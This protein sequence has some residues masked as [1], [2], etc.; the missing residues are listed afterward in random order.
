MVPVTITAQVADACSETTWK[1]ISISSNQ[2]VDAKGSGN[3]SPDWLITGDK[4]A[5][6]RAERTGKDKGGRIYTITIQA[7]DEAGNQ[8]AAATVTVTV[9]HDQGKKKK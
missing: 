4:T 9:P 7:T 2:A 3:T 1:I 6:L 5:S 8:S